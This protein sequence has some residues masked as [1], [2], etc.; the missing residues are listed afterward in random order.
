MKKTQH[1]GSLLFLSGVLLF[2]MMHIAIALSST[3]L[4]GVVYYSEKYIAALSN[5]LG[6]L[7][8][9]MSI[10]FMA[11]GLFILLNDISDERAKL[12]HKGKVYR[13]VEKINKS[14]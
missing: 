12:E 6:W 5:T 9:L 8:Y 2:G 11:S 1:L 14:T 10:I 4:T 13:V 7:P 3:K